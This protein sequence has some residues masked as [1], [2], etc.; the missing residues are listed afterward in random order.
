MINL[1]LMIVSFV[2]LIIS[3]T[4]IY[5]YFR[6][7]QNDKIRKV[8]NWFSLSFI[9]YLLLA[10]LFF[11]WSF[12]YIKYSSSDFN[13]I[14]S[15]ILIFLVLLFFKIVFLI[16]NDKKIFY[17]FIIYILLA[18]F[19]LFITNNFY[20]IILPLSYFVLLFLSF[21]Y[22]LARKECK[23]FG[24]A[25]ATYSAFSLLIQV[26][27]LVGFK[28][29]NISIIISFLFYLIVVIIFIKD[30]SNFPRNVEKIK[31]NNDSKIVNFV[32]YFIFVLILFNLILLSTLV[33]H[34]SGHIFS[35]KLL[36]CQYHTYVFDDNGRSL[37]T[38]TFCSNSLTG[39][40]VALGGI[41]LPLIVAIIFY[42][43]G[44]NLS[45]AISLIMLG[46]G[47]L[48]SSADLIVMGVSDNLVFSVDFVSVIIIVWGVV[49]LSKFKFNEL[50]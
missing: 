27:S 49:S 21:S 2:C 26:L 40:I 50:F 47:V 37:Q 46:S 15:S 41:I 25:L 33:I 20:K 43:V 31:Y 9:A 19:S 13:I 44:G 38:E 4:L 23:H 16:T 42:L 18:L 39:L 17:Y 34:E 8:S 5:N 1:T 7:Y 22:F 10:L 30:A 28:I 11:S 32:R 24:Y 12:E 3:L 48:M 14:Y 45:K 29:S 6:H 36:N 35:A